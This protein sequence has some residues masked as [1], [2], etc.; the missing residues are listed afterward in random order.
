MIASPLL[1]GI[2]AGGPSW[3]H[4]P[5]T[6]FWFLGYFAFFAVSLWLKAGRRAK[7]LPAARTYV[8]ASMVM[9]GV[10]LFTKPDL[11]RWA[12]AFI[13]PL[14]IGLWA[15]SARRERDLL[16]G[17]A[18]VAG[19]CLM[20]PVAYDVGAGHVDQRAWT[21]ALVQFLYFA[22]TVFYVKSAIRE[23]GNQ[24]FLWISVGFHVL[25]TLISAL[26]A[27][28]LVGVF[29]LLAVRAAALPG[30]GWTPKRLGMLEI[31]ATV[32]VA[33]ISLLCVA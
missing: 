2:I 27:W 8:V 31:P 15:A 28:P 23:R 11:I 20:T 5:L 18:T 12:P 24:A 32:L 17:L 3:A 14:G 6:A 4:V 25:A 1:V 26:I 30:L 33:G 29:G 7:W 22:G 19:A 16:T 9:G 10:V 21:L 13:A